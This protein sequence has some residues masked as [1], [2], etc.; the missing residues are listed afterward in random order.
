MLTIKSKKGGSYKWS[1]GYTNLSNVANIEKKLP[2][3]YIT[4][5]GYG[6]TAKCRKYINNLVYGEDYPPFKNGVPDYAKLKHP[7]VQKKLRK[8]K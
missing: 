2:K 7:L 8:F 3:N 4:K 6:I 5:D 1:V